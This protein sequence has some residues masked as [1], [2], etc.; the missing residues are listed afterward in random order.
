[1]SDKLTVGVVFG[2]RSQE[3]E[4]SIRSAESVIGALDAT[5]YNI[6]PIGITKEGEWL[7]GSDDNKFSIPPEEFLKDID[8]M[9]PLLH[10]TY[11]EDGAVQ[12]LFEML[13][14]PYVGAGVTGSAVGM[15]KAVFKNVM[16]AQGLPVLPYALLVRSE[17]NADNETALD[18]LEAV[19]EYPM[20][21]KPANLGSSVGISKCSE[22]IDLF[23][24]IQAAAKYD[25]RIVVEQA[26]KNVREFEIAVLGNDVLETS[27]VGELRPSR[28]FYD[29][30]AKYVTDDTELLIPAK[31]DARQVKKVRDLALAAY[32]AIDGA[33]MGRVDFLLDVDTGTFYI[34]EINTIP[35]FTSISMY[36]KL[37][38]AT[39][40]PY[41]EL[42]DRLI[43]LALERHEEKAALQH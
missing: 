43:A 1:M 22:R 33:G 6:V 36:P 41:S 39:H 13:N 25:R 14:V 20:F 29:Y 15:D 24:G 23:D 30:E 19:L 4:V 17:W 37:W 31:L 11:G 9:F 28:E 38:E 21:V 35:G 32:K 3:H 40:T 2:G 5:K 7:V 26:V 12:G 18:Q 34:N 42:L 10:G 27:V 8:V 16:E